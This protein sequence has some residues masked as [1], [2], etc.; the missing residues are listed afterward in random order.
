[1]TYELALPQL[2]FTIE[3]NKK[4]LKELKGS[5][6]CKAIEYKIPLMPIAPPKKIAIGYNI[7]KRLPIEYKKPKR[8]AIEYK[9]SAEY[10]KSNQLTYPLQPKEIEYK[11][12]LQITCQQKLRAIEYKDALQI[13]ASPQRK[14]IKS[15][16]L[17]HSRIPFKNQLAYRAKKAITYR[18]KL[19]LSH[20]PKKV[21]KYH[22]LKAIEY[23]VKK[24][25]SMKAI[26]YKSS[27][28]LSNKK[29]MVIPH[30]TGKSIEFKQMKAIEY[31]STKALQYKKLKM[32]NYKPVKTINYE[33]VNSVWMNWNVNQLSPPVTSQNEKNIAK[34]I[35]MNS[36]GNANQLK[37][38]RPV[39]YNGYQSNDYE[40][41]NKEDNIVNPD[42]SYLVDELDFNNNDDNDYT[43]FINEI[44]EDYDIIENN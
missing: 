23:K 32:I 17:N 44:S 26:E 21:L 13:T 12:N 11:N 43:V 4:D 25:K 2:Q 30:K 16:T 7:L 40:I 39:N 8:L 41:I 14:A 5:P 18:L 31:K 20:Q 19:S 34:N 38:S 27:K 36:W 15:L 28:A 3:N 1:M 37:E 33:P 29:W 35:S 10:I 42:K 9:H 6:T 24:T 22:H